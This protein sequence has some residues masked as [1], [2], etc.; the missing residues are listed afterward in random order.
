MSND[1]L[2]TLFSD[3]VAFCQRYKTILEEW[4]SLIERGK[5]LQSKQ[6]ALPGVMPSAPLSAA[7]W[8]N[9]TPDFFLPEE[10]RGAHP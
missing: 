5:K 6:P 3:Q 2:Q 9:Q 4:A 10:Y 1:D 8:A 7:W